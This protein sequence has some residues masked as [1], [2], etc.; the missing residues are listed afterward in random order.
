MSDGLHDVCNACL[1]SDQIR[2]G[3]EQVSAGE[4]SDSPPDLEADQQLV[5]KLDAV[6][7]MAYA[8]FCKE[9]DLDDY[10]VFVYKED[11]EDYASSEE[12]NEIIPL[13][14]GRELII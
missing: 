11:A 8:V 12:I 14:P 7:P 3:S 5:D 10:K 2:L 9:N 1:F 13:Y 4:F 6:E